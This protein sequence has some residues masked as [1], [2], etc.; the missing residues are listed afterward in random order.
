MSRGLMQT[1]QRHYLNVMD[2]LQRELNDIQEQI[3]DLSETSAPRTAAQPT[4]AQ[5]TTTTCNSTLPPPHPVLAITF[6][7]R[8]ISE[9]FSLVYG[10]NWACTVVMSGRTSDREEPSSSSFIVG[11]PTKKRAV[12]RRT[13]EKWVVENNRA[14]TSWLKLDAGQS[15]PRVFSEVCGLFLV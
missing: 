10:Y 11:L 12:S 2:H 6:S 14:N 1:L 3:T 5:P 8:T 4:P 15:W 7:N 13:L 9:Q